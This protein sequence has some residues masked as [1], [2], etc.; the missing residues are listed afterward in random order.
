MQS[1]SSKGQRHHGLA[2]GL[3]QEEQERGNVGT[4]VRQEI[5]RPV[6]STTA[7]A[8]AA[9]PAM[10]WAFGLFHASTALVSGMLLRRIDHLQQRAAAEQQHQ[11]SQSCSRSNLYLTGFMLHSCG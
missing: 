6:D 11:S 3:A 8:A 4:P 5:A 9:A 10:R 1:A 2:A 7:M